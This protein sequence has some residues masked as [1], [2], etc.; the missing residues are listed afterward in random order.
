MRNARR[1]KEMITKKVLVP[2]LESSR[3]NFFSRVGIYQVQVQ[4]YFGISCDGYLQ[5]FQSARCSL[6]GGLSWI[7]EH[8]ASQH[9]DLVSARFTMV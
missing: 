5:L 6:V 7:M 2:C 3:Q 8:K 9:R 1:I 4:H